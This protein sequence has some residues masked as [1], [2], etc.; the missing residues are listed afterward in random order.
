MKVLCNKTTKKI[1]GFSRWD[2]IEF[3]P[4]THIVIDITEMPDMDLDKLN[5]KNTGIVKVTQAKID[6]NETSKQARII[7]DRNLNALTHDF[8]DGRI[9]QT[10]S[11]DESNIRNAIEIMTANNIPSIGWI[12]LDN[13]KHL[14]TS[15]ELQEALVAGQ[16][17]AM[18]IWSDYNP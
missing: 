7:R 15:V 9:I 3:N 4:D 1:E 17:A 13:T 8:G 11:K 6:A 12:M 5:D 2:D 18:Q 16:L 14:I 10:R